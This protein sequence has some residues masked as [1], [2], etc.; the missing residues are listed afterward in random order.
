MEHDDSLLAMFC[1]APED[2]TRLMM[3]GLGYQFMVSNTPTEES[4]RQ[5]EAVFSQQSLQLHHHSVFA[6]EGLSARASFRATMCV[7]HP[8]QVFPS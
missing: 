7:S 2:E 5:V 3:E 8:T 6:K 4:K 1:M